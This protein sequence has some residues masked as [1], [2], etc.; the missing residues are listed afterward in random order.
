MLWVCFLKNVHK[1]QRNARLYYGE[2]QKKVTK[3]L[4]TS[5]FAEAT[6][7][8]GFHR[9]KTDFYTT[10]SAKDTK[11]EIKQK[12]NLAMNFRDLARKKD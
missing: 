3:E 6:T 9:F 7:R 8:Q 4:A 1:K 10:K 5:V 12:K 2:K 11:E